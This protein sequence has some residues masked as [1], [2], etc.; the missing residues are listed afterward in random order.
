MFHYLSVVRSSSVEK[1]QKKAGCTFFVIKGDCFNDLS[2]KTFKALGLI[3]IVTTVSSTQQCST[4]ADQLVASHLELFQGI[5]KLKDCQVNLHINTDIRP[6]C[7]PHRRVPFHIR[8]KVEDELRKLEA[9]D[10]IE[11]VTGPTPW[12]SPIVAAP[13]P[14]APDEVRVCVDMRQANKAIQRERHITPT[15][16]DVVHE[17]NG[18]TVFSKLDLRTGYHQLELHPD[19]RYITTFSTHLGLRRYKRLGFGVSSAAEVFQNAICQA[20]HGLCGVKNL[21]MT[22]LSTVAPRVNMTRTSERCFRDS[23]KVVSHSI[24]RNVSSTK[25]GP[26]SSASSSSADP[27]KAAAVHDAA[28][29][30]QPTDVKSLLGMT[31]YCSRFIKDFSGSERTLHGHG[32]QNRNVHFRHR[33]TV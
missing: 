8:Q 9:D 24:V 27:K 13:K 33:R 30:Q 21:M 6:A 16:D 2:Y 15:M 22:S 11:E 4:V 10:I 25:P 19:S 12:V 3:K 31:N 7:Q 29:P 1:G 32:V 26:S 17:L 14:K 28:D 18:A 20:L 23:K 5:G